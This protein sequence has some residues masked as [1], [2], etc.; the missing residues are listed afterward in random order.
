MTDD[1]SYDVIV[2]GLGA[3]GSAAA[4]QLARRGVRVLGLEQYQPA[5]DLG[6]SHGE[7]RM[8]RKA[9]FEHPA[10]V[11]LVL[12]AYE[13]WRELEAQTG[14]E[15][16]SVTGGLMIGAPD[17]QLVSGAR[18]SAERWDLSYRMLERAELIAQF[19]TFTPPE[20]FVALWEPDA[21]LVRPE[22]AVRAQLQVAEAHGAQLRFGERVTGWSAGGAGPGVEVVTATGRWTAERLIVCPGPW[23]PEV[24]PDLQVP[25][26]VERQ[27]TFW[28]EPT[29]S[30]EPF[31]IGRHPVWIWETADPEVVPYGFPALDA[32]SGLKAAIFRGGQSCSP[33]DISRT[34]SPEEVE[35]MTAVLD[36]L[37][38]SLA[39]RFL[40]ATTCMYTN[41]PDHHFV[42]GE[43]PGLSEVFV[44]CGFSGH[45]F[46]F[47]PVI[48]E[49]LADLACGATPR[50]L[51][52]ELFSPARV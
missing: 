26:Q 18:A 30:I 12:R 44:A 51:P 48:G 43:L 33:A 25:L 42:L 41:S 22:A 8:I 46:K 24:L 11:P 19:P 15:L 38:P 23:A 7:S 5:H 4:A 28:F 31:L 9:Y 34:V 37:A 17:S 20:G 6:S 52:S 1:S 45:G 29:G 3:M 13:L 14:A 2:V 27:V 39:G 21:G 49:L 35:A 32:S 10:Y 47:A 16:L 40:R 36:G 50:D